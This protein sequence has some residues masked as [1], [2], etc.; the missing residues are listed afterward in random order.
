MT[1]LLHIFQFLRDQLLENLKIQGTSTSSRNSKKETLTQL[2]SCQLSNI[3]KNTVF[4]KTSAVAAS[5]KI[6]KY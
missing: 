2:F 5:V 1:F 4:D 6:E 3:F